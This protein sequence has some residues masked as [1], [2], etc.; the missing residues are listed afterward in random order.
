MRSNRIQ[1]KLR[2][3]GKPISLNFILY[4]DENAAFERILTRAE[5]S[6]GRRE[7]VCLRKLMERLCEAKKRNA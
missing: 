4:C 5:Q 6:E 2:E 3:I 1:G 7:P